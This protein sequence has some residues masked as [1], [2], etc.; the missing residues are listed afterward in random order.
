M[1]DCSLGW[2]GR[3]LRLGI[4]AFAVGV[5]PAAMAQGVAVQAANNEIAAVHVTPT[6][7]LLA[8]AAA[9]DP[10]PDAPSAT[11]AMPAPAQDTQIRAYLPPKDPTSAQPPVAPLRWKRIPAGYAYS[12]LSARDK[13]YIGFRDTYS[14]GDIGDWFLASGW[15]HLTNGQPHYGVDRGAYGMRLGAA[16][17]NE[18]A[19]GIFDDSVFAVIFR[20]DPRFFVEGPNHDVL[21]RTVHAVSRVVIT[22]NDNGSHGPNLALFAS[23]A[24]VHGVDMLFYP[25]TD[26]DFDSYMTG[27]GGSLAGAALG[28][29]V[30]EFTPDLLKAVHLKK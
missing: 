18:T 28:Y 20:E 30:D 24:A 25:K 1:M 14:P 9:S 19:E 17:I 12:K 4:L 10:L 7:G 5:G 16:A 21:H 3:A 13:V 8:G 22:R 29:V 6:D 23:Y 11:L 27:F 15:S 26:Q 2:G